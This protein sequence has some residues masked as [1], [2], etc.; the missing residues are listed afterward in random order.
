MGSHTHK[1]KSLI[2]PAALGHGVYSDSNVNE[3][4]KQKEKFLG[5]RE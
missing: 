2:L 1:K 3:Y 4:Q 5:S